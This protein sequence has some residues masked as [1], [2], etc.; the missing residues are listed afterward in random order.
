MG[1]CLPRFSTMPFLFCDTETTCRYAS[2][3]D[4]SYWLSTDTP[5]PTNMVS[6]TGDML[7]SYISRWDRRA[8][9]HIYRLIYVSIHFL[10][11]FSYQGSQRLIYNFLF[12]KQIQN[13]KISTNWNIRQENVNI[14]VC[15]YVRFRCSVCETTSNVIAI[16]S[17]TTEI[18]DCPQSW[19]SLWTGYSFVMVKTKVIFFL[20]TCWTLS[21]SIFQVFVLLSSIL[22]NR[23]RCR[24]LLSAPGFS[25]FMSRTFPPSAVHWVSWQGDM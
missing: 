23:S 19:E 4:Y 24:G 3:N 17:Q 25:W 8:F 14:D 13:T 1:S 18:P 5:A 20:L 6:I 2:R 7:A 15:L 16:H 10:K 9:P 11:I 12:L 21:C 22:A